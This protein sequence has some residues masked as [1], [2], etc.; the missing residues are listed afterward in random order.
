MSQLKEHF[1]DT[2]NPISIIGLLFIFGLACDTN[3][4]HEEAF[5][6]A[7]PFFVESVLAVTLNSPMFAAAHITPVFASVNT[8]KLFIE[9]NLQ[10]SNLEVINYFLKKFSID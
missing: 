6:R 10:R 1:L 5:M 4:T 2:S 7:L 9:K 8:T 3:N